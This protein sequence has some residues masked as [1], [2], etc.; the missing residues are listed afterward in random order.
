MMRGLETK[1]DRER[2]GRI[3]PKCKG[4]LFL[5]E[6]MKCNYKIGDKPTMNEWLKIISQ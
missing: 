2:F 4:Y 1:R 3:C 6:C 5:D